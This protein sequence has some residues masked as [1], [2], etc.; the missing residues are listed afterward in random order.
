[1]IKQIKQTALAVAEF[2]EALEDFIE[3]ASEVLQPVMEQWRLDKIAEQEYRNL[4]EKQFWMGLM[5][6]E[7]ERLKNN[8]YS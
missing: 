1:M 2:A 8:K 5:W 4:K 6:S 3:T 7:E